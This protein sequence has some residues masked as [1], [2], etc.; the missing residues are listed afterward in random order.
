MSSA[1]GIS[2]KVLYLVRRQ[3]KN[4]GF[5]LL[6]FH[7]QSKHAFFNCHDFGFCDHFAEGLASYINATFMQ[8]LFPARFNNSLNNAMT[9]LNNK[10]QQKERGIQRNR[11]GIGDAFSD[12]IG[13]ELV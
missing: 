1:I 12:E 10:Q 13:S 11:R 4:V 8:T 7:P 9:E 2:Q 5:Q 6:H 3:K